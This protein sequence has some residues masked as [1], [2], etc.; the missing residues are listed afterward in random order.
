MNIEFW[1]SG[2]GVSGF[3]LGSFGFRVGEFWVSGW[4]RVVFI[5]S[6]SIT[7]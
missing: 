5:N 4:E 7:K 6:H 1:V 3:E 2:W